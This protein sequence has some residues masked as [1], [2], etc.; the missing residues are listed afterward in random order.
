MR[1]S[2]YESLR[3]TAFSSQKSTQG[4]HN[5]PPPRFLPHHDRGCSSGT[6]R[7]LNNAISCHISDQF[8]GSLALDE[9]QSMP[10]KRMGAVGPVSMLCCTRAVL[11][12]SSSPAAK[13]STKSLN[14]CHSCSCCSVLK[15]S[16]LRRPNSSTATT[17]SGDGE[18]D[19]VCGG[20]GWG[21]L[22]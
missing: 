15:C 3:V 22:V 11:V 10:R 7:G 2:G 16:P 1:G 21:V 6:V 17:V 8:F 4:C 20:N 14:R 18:A 5:P 13:I 9:R 19:G 12:Q